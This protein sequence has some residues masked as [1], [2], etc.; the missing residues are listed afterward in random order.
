MV[1][2]EKGTQEKENIYSIPK[3]GLFKISNGKSEEHSI[4]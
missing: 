2:R 1:Q 3:F 4:V